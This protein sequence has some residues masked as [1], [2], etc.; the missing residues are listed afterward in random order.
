MARNGRGAAERDDIVTRWGDM[1]VM[2][3]VYNYIYMYTV[4]IYVTSECL[5]DGY[6]IIYMVYIDIDV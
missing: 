1:Y 6:Y 5:I 3:N 4:Y 2:Y